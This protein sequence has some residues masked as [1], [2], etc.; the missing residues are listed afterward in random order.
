MRNVCVRRG[1][2]SRFPYRLDETHVSW[3]GSWTLVDSPS[4][5]NPF[6]IFHFR[7]QGGGDDDDDGGGTLPAN[8]TPHP[9]M[10]RY[11]ISRKGTPHSDLI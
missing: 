9:N 7:G 10:R 6:Y 8:P 11:P 2:Y 4:I 3:K 5:Q 1:P